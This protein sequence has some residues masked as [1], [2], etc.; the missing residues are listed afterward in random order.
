MI[1][2]AFSISSKKH[3]YMSKTTLIPF[4]EMSRSSGRIGAFPFSEFTG[5]GPAIPPCRGQYTVFSGRKLCCQTAFFP[6]VTSWLSLMV[7]GHPGIGNSGLG[8]MFPGFKIR[9]ARYQVNLYLHPVGI[10]LPQISGEVQRDFIPFDV[11][12]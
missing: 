4:P 2:F 6:S 9:S 8:R 5:P 10:Q 3:E 11:P 12:R 1:L 7:G